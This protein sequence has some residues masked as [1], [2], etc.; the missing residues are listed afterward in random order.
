MTDDTTDPTVDELIDQLDADTVIRVPFM[1]HTD[2]YVYRF[3]SGIMVTT[4]GD[5]SIRE[6]G[7][8]GLMDEAYVRE[9][10]TDKTPADKAELELVPFAESP[11]AAGWDDAE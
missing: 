2:Q 5:S 9:V 8:I 10:L 4:W 3:P 6:G 7:S 1:G 11:Y